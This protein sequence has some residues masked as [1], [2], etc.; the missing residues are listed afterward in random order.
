M[1]NKIAVALAFVGWIAVIGQYILMIENRTQPVSETS[2][3]FVS[4]FTILT[5]IIVAFYFTFLVLPED[6]RAILTA[7][8]VYITM[9]GS[10]YQILLRHVWQPHGMQLVVNEL[11]HTVIPVVVIIFWYLYED[12]S[13][14]RYG[15]L[16]KWTVYPVVYLTYILIYGHYSGFYPYYFVDVTKL[17]METVLATAAILMIVFFVVS[18]VFIFVGKTFVRGGSTV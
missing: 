18:S 8:T 6:R 7:V 12:T 11:L 16:V 5:N 17:G 15:Q 1:K 10:V 3:R 4:Y 14:L 2:V 13:Q 9:V